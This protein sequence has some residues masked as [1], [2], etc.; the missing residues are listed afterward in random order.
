MAK[1]KITLIRSL[2]GRPED[3]RVT[4]RT[5]GLRKLHSSV[6]QEDTPQIRGMINKVSHLVKVEEI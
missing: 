6:I 1:L 4:V 3:Q 5:L 2:I